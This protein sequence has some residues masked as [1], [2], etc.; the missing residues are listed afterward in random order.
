MAIFRKLTFSNQSPAMVR[1]ML[2]MLV[3]CVVP[4]NVR[5]ENWP[6]W[7]GVHGNG[8]STDRGFPLT[9]SATEAVKWTIDL[10][11]P[12]NSSPIVWDDQ[13]F[14]TCASQEGRR[15]SLMCFNRT[16]GQ[17]TWER[18]VAVTADEPTHTKPT[19][20]ARRRQ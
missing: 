12:G 2:A 16:D 10:P 8:H 17:L 4:A 20:T 3:I 15:R 1:L 13:I 18:H 7:R 19:P 11:G 6:T 14:V 5:A 9:W